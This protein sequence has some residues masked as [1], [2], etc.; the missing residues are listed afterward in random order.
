MYFQAGE[1]D[2]KELDRKMTG[3]VIEPDGRGKQTVLEWSKMKRER[4]REKEGKM[5]REGEGGRRKR[6]V[7]RRRWD[8]EDEEKSEYE[9]DHIQC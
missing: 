2:E 5:K 4:E 3:R 7:G 1:D 6:G 8:K 9:C